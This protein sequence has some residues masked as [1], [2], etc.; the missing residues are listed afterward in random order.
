MIF[1]TGIDIV[2]VG[3]IQKLMDRSGDKFLQRHFTAKEIEYCG[4]KPHGI[5]HFA[6]CFAAKEAVY[7]ALKMRWEAGFSWKNIEIGHDLSGVP[8]VILAGT[9]L[10][11]F[12]D[13]RLTDIEVSISHTESYAAASAVLWGSP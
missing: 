6:G 7:K 8:Q 11:R 2:E 5:L 13:S 3:R 1:R 10:S 4:A 12:A 9:A